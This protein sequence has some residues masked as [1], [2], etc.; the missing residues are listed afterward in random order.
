MDGPKLASRLVR[1]S[2]ESSHKRDEMALTLSARCGLMHRSKNPSLFDHFVGE[3]EQLIR[4][5]KTERFGGTG[6]NY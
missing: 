3:R 6:I 4:H 5:S 1:C 2:F